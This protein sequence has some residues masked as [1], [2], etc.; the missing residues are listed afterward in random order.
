MNS[1]TNAGDILQNPCQD[2]FAEYLVYPGAVQHASMQAKG[3]PGG[4]PRMG[5]AVRKT[6]SVFLLS[7]NPRA[8]LLDSRK[9]DSRI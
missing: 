9:L 8:N 7:G 3:H 2:S 6:K 5:D 4:M 1:L